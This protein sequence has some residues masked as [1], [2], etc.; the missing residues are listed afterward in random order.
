MEISVVVFYL[1]MG[2]PGDHVIS[3]LHYMPTAK[4]MKARDGQE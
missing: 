4:L 2:S 3:I 1:F